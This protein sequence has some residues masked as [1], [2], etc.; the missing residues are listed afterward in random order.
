[1]TMLRSGLSTILRYSRASATGLRFDPG[2]AEV[3]QRRFG[4]D[5]GDHG[6]EYRTREEARRVSLAL[7]ATYLSRSKGTDMRLRST[8][9]ST[10][11][12]G[13]ET[14]ML[15]L[16]TSRYFTVTGVGTRIV[17]LL[18]DD[19]SLAE[20]VGAIVDEYEVDPDNAQ[21]DVSTFVERLRA[22]EL[23]V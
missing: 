7:Q 14:I 11:I 16:S 23:L 4:G 6:R 3:V 5:R 17:E 9:I 22:A 12:L 13:D 10:R 18:A 2:A 20:L 19:T 1:M 8:D 21:R 15:N